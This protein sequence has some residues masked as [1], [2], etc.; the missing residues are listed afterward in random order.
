MALIVIVGLTE[1]VGLLLDQLRRLVPRSLRVEV[2]CSLWVAVL[3]HLFGSLRV[4][5]I[6]N[7]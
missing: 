6:S 4:G 1:F 3:P 7:R 2:P 5:R